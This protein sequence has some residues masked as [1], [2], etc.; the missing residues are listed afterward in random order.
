NEHQ[1]VCFFVDE[2]RSN[3]QDVVIPFPV[4]FNQFNIKNRGLSGCTILGGGSISLIID[5]DSIID[6]NWGS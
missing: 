6:I 3:Q 5:A 1:A 2:I 4:Y